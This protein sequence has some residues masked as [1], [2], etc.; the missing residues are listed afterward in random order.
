MGKVERKREVRERERG[1]EGEEEEREEGE[2]D[3]Y[4]KYILTHRQK[5]T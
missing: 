2:V 5:R 1:G 4:C 3:L